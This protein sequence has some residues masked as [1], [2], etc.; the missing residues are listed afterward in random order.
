[1][2]LSTWTSNSNP[3]GKLQGTRSQLRHT[4]FFGRLVMQLGHLLQEGSRE[5]EQVAR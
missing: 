3:P 4:A 5:E 2:K 1:M